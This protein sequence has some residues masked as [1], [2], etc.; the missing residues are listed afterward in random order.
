MLALA[1]RTGGFVADVSTNQTIGE[2]ERVGV[3][4]HLVTIPD[5]AE[6]AAVRLADVGFVTGDDSSAGIEHR[7]LSDGPIQPGETQ[8]VRAGG[9]FGNFNAEAVPGLPTDIHHRFHIM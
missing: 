2:V 4:H 6:D 3:L 8:G 7:F 1:E 5:N 9:R